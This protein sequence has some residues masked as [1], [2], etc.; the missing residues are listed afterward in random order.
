MYCTLLIHTLYIAVGGQ[1]QWMLKVY[2]LCS[3]VAVTC[4]SQNSN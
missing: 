1:E 2:S 3:G 4:S